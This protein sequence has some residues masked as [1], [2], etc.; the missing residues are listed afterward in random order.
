MSIKVGV[1]VQGYLRELYPHLGERE[2]VIS[3]KPLTV[4]EIIGWLGIKPQTVLFVMIE[5]RIVNKDYLVE[6][7]TELVLVS[8]PAGG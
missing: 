2:E 4:R 3:D 6:S 7:D 8:P 1:I 5:D